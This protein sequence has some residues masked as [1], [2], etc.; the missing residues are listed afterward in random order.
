MN[1][2][3]VVGLLCVMMI[4]PL[5]C[6]VAASPSSYTYTRQDGPPR[7]VVSDAHGAWLATF[8]DGSFTV[9][10]L[11]PT[12]TF[13]ELS[14]A[15]P[16]ATTTWVRV[17]PAPFAGTVDAAWLTRALTDTD[18]DIF[19]LAMQYLHGA[20]PLYGDEDLQIAGEAHY[21][22]LLPNGRRAEG[23]DFSDYLGVPWTVGART[24]Q[25][26]PQQFQS[27]DCSGFMRMVWGY[28]GGL[29][30]GYAPAGEAL[31]RHSWELFANAP[32]TVLIPNSGTRPSDLTPLSPGDLVFFKWDP[33][34]V[35]PVDHVGMYLGTDTAGH[36]RFISS[37]QTNDGPTLGDTGGASRLDGNG[38]W[39][40][41]FIAARRL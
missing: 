23:A 31:P 7:T 8:T 19:A 30:L 11:G 36:A 4:G 35:H 2:L 14:A 39:A 29:P 28:R 1:R 24:R 33:Q 37:R 16:V 12:R 10:L 21:G 38:L 27:L 32:G 15:H 20:P 41:A 3:L 22:P 6:A 18:P 5:P 13:A 25:P 17:L 34:N 26:D 40:R 9:T